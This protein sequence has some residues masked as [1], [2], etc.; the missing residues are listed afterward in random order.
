MIHKAQP[1]SAQRLHAVVH[2]LVQGVNFRAYTIHK[3]TS[4][5]LKGWVR[6]CS[7]GTVETV[8][9]GP[10]H[11]LEAFLAFLHEGS[12]AARVTDVDVSWTEA[13]G[14]FVGFKVRGF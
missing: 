4:L 5:N 8:A 2:G 6:N 12:P 3:A 13:T 10:R 9:E 14:E 7:D 11:S 1:E